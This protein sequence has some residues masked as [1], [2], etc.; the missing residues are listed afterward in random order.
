M[1]WIGHAL[2]CSLCTENKE[3]DDKIQRKDKVINLLWKDVDIL[4]RNY[5]TSLPVI[6]KNYEELVVKVNQ[7]AYQNNLGVSTKK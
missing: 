7:L 3:F 1:H 5:D 4:N 6:K 2:N